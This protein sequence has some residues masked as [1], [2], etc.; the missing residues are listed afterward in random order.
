ML[1]L[2]ALQC[3]TWHFRYVYNNNTA[4]LHEP[5]ADAVVP[6]RF[7]SFGSEDCIAFPDVEL[8]AGGIGFHAITGVQ[9]NH[10]CVVVVPGFS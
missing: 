6:R 7:R 1:T 10:N 4:I 2:Y 9:E 8:F 5:H 3:L